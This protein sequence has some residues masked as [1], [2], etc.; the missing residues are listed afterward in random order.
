M[1]WR[2]ANGHDL[3]GANVVDGKAVR[4]SYGE[5]AP[6]IDFDRTPGYRSSSWLLPLVYGSLAV[7][8][9]TGLL[10]PTRAIVRRRLKA[11]LPIEGRQLWT[12]RSSRIAAWTILA[13]LGGWVA[14]LSALFGD[15]ANAASIN[16]L[17]VPLELLSII[18][19]VGGFAVMLW[20]AYT[21]WRSG[22]RW[23][24]KVW[25]IL[26]VVAAGTILYTGLVFK[27]IGLTSNY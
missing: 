14:A 13:V 20:Y 23:P 2:D 26:L 15:L 6:I 25:S 12:Y 11:T 8:F 7:L 4:F 10:W 5:L 21:V 27:L 9:L 22:W 18:V 24:A 17:L 19:F 16:S 3:L 1:L